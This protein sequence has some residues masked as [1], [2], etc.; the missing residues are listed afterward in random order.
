MWPRLRG[1][2]EAGLSQE[3]QLAF[4]TPDWQRD[5]EGSTPQG[6]YGVAFQLKVLN[7]HGLKGVFLVE[8]LFADALG[9]EPLSRVVNMIQ[10]AGHEVQLHVHPEWLP[11]T[12]PRILPGRE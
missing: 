12:L 9:L 6:E 11:W 7:E 2:P 1:W 10:D 8:A 3:Q 5:M 4:L